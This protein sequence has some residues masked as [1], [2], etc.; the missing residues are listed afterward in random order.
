MPRVLELRC[1]S[2]WLDGREV[3]R[4]VEWTVERGEHWALLGANGS[5]KTTLLRVL[6][7]YLW[8]G[9]GSLT[10]LGRTFGEVD[11]RE[12]R[13]SIGFVSVS[14]AQRMPPQLD[15]LSIVASGFAASLG[16]S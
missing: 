4:D 1:P 5:G 12:L 16:L 15:A 3:L 13:R 6:G 2:L 11:L 8:P 7:G 10:V 9:R 14:L